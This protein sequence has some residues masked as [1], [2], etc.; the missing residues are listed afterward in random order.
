MKQL[1]NAFQVQEP[2]LQI[3]RLARIPSS[4]KRESPVQQVIA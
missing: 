3:I 4:R 2:R 1:T